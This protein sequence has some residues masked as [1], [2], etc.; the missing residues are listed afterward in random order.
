M[1]VADNAGDHVLLGLRSPG[2]LRAGTTWLA[3]GEGLC[4]QCAVG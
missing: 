2:A 1:T 4:P 3:G